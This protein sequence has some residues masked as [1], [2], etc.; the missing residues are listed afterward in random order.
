MKT[1]ILLINLILI[2]FIGYGQQ[3]NYE[4]VVYLKSGSIIRGIIVEQVPN[5]QIKI[6]TKDRNVFVFSMDEIE[7]IT[8]ELISIKTTGNTNETI[9]DEKKSEYQKSDGSAVIIELGT[10]IYRYTSNGSQAAFSLRT[11]FGGR[12]SE[13]TSMGLQF[14]ID[15]AG[16]K[17]LGSPYKLSDAIFIPVGLGMRFGFLKSRGT[18]FLLRG[19]KV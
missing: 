11:L 2:L 6:Q 10:A 17:N 12:V 14:G 8:K 5:K 9:T 7:K 1:L 3:S 4:E 15:L 19:W 13:Y 16:R 18:P